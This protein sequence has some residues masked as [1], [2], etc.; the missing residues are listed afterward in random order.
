MEEVE[1]QLNLIL[2]DIAELEE[3]V[4]DC[5]ERLRENERLSPQLEDHVRC[6]MNE[7]SYWSA[8]CSTT[9]ESP[10]I[11]MRR[12]EVQ[13]SRMKRLSELLDRMVSEI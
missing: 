10:H 12:M 4:W 3:H 6:V 11:L 8:L 1:R 9:S 2:I 13:L 7:V 5:L